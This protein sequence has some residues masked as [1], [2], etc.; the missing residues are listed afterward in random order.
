MVHTNYCK[1]ISKSLIWRRSLLWKTLSIS[2]Y[3]GTTSFTATLLWFV[4]LK[5]VS[6]VIKCNYTALP[7][8]W[9]HNDLAGRERSRN[10]LDQ[11]LFTAILCYESSGAQVHS[12]CIFFLQCCNFNAIEKVDEWCSHTCLQ[13]ASKLTVNDCLK[14]RKTT[15]TTFTSFWWKV[16]AAQT[17]RSE[18]CGTSERDVADVIQ[19]CSFKIVFFWVVSASEWLWC[20][21]RTWSYGQ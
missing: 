4:I 8:V 20:F 15:W 1:N 13:G 21:Q 3:P 18:W 10:R 11:F 7:S 6:D 17:F 2:L 14:S 16:I 19:S 12:R 9:H 5:T